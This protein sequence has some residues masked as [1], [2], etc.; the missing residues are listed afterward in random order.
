MF[1]IIKGE[2]MTA[3]EGEALESSL[4]RFIGPADSV[5]VY[6]FFRFGVHEII[7]KAQDIEKQIV[8]YNSSWSGDVPESFSVII[9]PDETKLS[10]KTICKTSLTNFVLQNYI[11]SLR[12]EK[13]SPCFFCIDSNKNFHP[14]MNLSN[15]IAYEKIKKL[16]LITVSELRRA[17]KLCYDQCIDP[18]IRKVALQTF[19]F[20]RVKLDKDGLPLRLTKVSPPWKNRRP[21]Q[22]SDGWKKLRKS[23][24]W[25]YQINFAI[26]FINSAG[27]K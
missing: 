21:V 2:K 17:Y 22:S 19:Q 27:R 13:I 15:P 16:E 20:I 3:I 18:R 6:G 11:K 14:K 5:M 24:N 8:T 26:K 10:T 4:D 23:A 7:K 9:Y 12:G 1:I 25:R